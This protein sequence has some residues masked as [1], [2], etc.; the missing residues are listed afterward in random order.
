MRGQSTA[1]CSSRRPPTEVFTLLGISLPGKAARVPSIAL[2]ELRIPT[3]SLQRDFSGYGI[4]RRD[5]ACAGVFHRGKPIGGVHI[6][7]AERPARPPANRGRS[8]NRRCTGGRPSRDT[9]GCGRRPRPPAGCPAVCR[10]D[11]S[12]CNYDKGTSTPALVGSP[13]TSSDS[14]VVPGGTSKAI[15]TSAVSPGFS[16]AWPPLR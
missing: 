3:N 12:A 10:S 7:A 16:S 2:L 11:T 8:Q 14:G 6:A 4:S 5:A 1:R 15:A 9:A 13:C